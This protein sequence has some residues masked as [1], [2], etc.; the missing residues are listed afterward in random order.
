M[1]DNPHWYVV[2]TNEDDN[3]IESLLTLLNRYSVVRRWKRQPYRMVSIDGWDFWDI[4]PVINTKP[5][6]M[7]GWDG[8]PP[9]PEGWLLAE[10]HR[11]LRGVEMP[12][13]LDVLEPSTRTWVYESD[14]WGVDPD[15]G[16]EP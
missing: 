2:V 9:P 12:L 16:L 15:S 8:A 5:S 10:W 3:R 13:L 11:N 6:A 1:A 4:P 7:G 14:H